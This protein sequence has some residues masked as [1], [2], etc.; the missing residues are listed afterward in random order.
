MNT[1]GIPMSTL[2]EG[3]EAIPSVIPSKGGPENYADHAETKEYIQHNV[4]PLMRTAREQRAQLD[5]TMHDCEKLAQ[6]VHDDNRKYIGRS[7]AYV[8]VYLR[9]ENTQVS[10]LTRGLFPSDEFMEVQAR[11]DGTE[12]S[13]R[14]VKDYMQYEFEKCA[15]LR[16]NVKPFLRQFVRH[17]WSVAKVWFHKP[18]EA[19]LGATPTRDTAI[20]GARFRARSVFNV[21]VWPHNIDDM[22]EATLVFEDINVPHW[23]ADA[24]FEE[25]VWV[26]EEEAESAGAD[27]QHVAAEQERT[28]AMTGNA[29]VSVDGIGDTHG[30]LSKWHHYVECYVRLKL[31]KYDGQCLAQVILANN[32]PVMVRPLADKHGRMP[33]LIAR[34]QP[35]AG[36][37]YCHGA[38]FT[39]KDL[40][41]L[42][43]DFA[44]Q[45]NDN[46]TYALNPVAVIN[47][48]M[49][50]KMPSLSP[51]AVIESLD[52]NGVKWDRPP[53]EQ[54]QYGMNLVQMWISMLMDNVGAPPILQGTNAGKGARTATSS[55]I[56]QHNA[57]SPI[58]DSI[59]D[60]E[61]DVMTPLMHMVFALGQQYRD[62]PTFVRLLD[63]TARMV[64]PAQ[65]VGDFDFRWLASSQAANQQQRAMQIMQLL[66]MVQ[67]VAPLLAAKGKTIDPEPLLRRLYSDAFGFRGF[68]Q[69]VRPMNPMEMMQ[70]GGMGAPP[71]S[72][73]PS[74][75][76][77]QVGGNQE[78]GAP[79]PAPGEGGAFSDV[80]D[81]ADQMAAMMGMM[82][83]MGGG[84]M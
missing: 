2:G 18:E 23:F 21:H 38:A 8:P 60:I 39:G 59:E 46:G 66:Q 45:L 7:S 26:N 61:A 57:M 41:Y 54:L 1:A 82:G 22:E 63:G 52:P 74:P 69:F 50:A 64:D 11:H 31:P 55:Q 47:P 78:E 28:A 62:E 71:A 33:Y 56:L 48:S 15:R 79:P 67:S 51:G 42:V 35:E 25:G 40:Q 30:K 75:E 24:M 58:Q 32:V 49:I 81:G 37:F 16:K 73:A 76:G 27:P 68:D 80:R 72:G 9:A 84:G 83:G 36:Q 13:A 34:A 14:I 70:Q 6:L 4:V 12:E 44:N 10:Q 29:S 20:Q 19:G 3:D 77:Q 43:N 53:V 65:L 5:R 17:G